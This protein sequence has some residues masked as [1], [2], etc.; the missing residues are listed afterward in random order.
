M[1]QTEMYRGPT[2]YPLVAGVRGQDVLLYQ[3]FGSYQ[4]EW[5]MLA[6]DATNYYVYKDWYGSCSGCDAYEA[7]MDY[8]TDGVPMEKALKFAESYPPFIE[9]PH[10]TM[11]NLVKNGTLGTVLPANINDKYSDIDLPAFTSDM[12]LAAK[13]AENVD[14]TADDIL[15]APNQ[16]LKQRAL[17]LFGY[18]RFVAEVEMEEIHRD[19]ENALLRKGDIVFAYVKDSSTPRRYLLRVPPNS[20]T[21]HEAIAWTFN[22]RPD[23]YRPLVET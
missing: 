2:G 19:G 9:I 23:E 17:K 6:R 5:M 3:Q 4:G 12:A 10:E 16:E 7:E 14:V 1:S 8:S 22:M 11:R 20:K 18:E 15:K 21:V 13:L